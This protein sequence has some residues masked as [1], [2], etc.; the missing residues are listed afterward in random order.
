[1]SRLNEPRQP[2]EAEGGTRMNTQG[3]EEPQIKRRGEIR[4]EASGPR[5]HA[6]QIKT[7]RGGR[8]YKGAPGGPPQVGPA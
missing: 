4:G 5:R 1:M 7:I 2:A 8:R 3:T 6:N